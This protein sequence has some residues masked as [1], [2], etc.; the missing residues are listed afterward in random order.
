MT[1][2]QSGKA[3]KPTGKSSVR[4]VTVLLPNEIY[5]TYE[6]VARREYITIPQVVTRVA[7]EFAAT[8]EQASRRRLETILDY[9]AKRLGRQEGPAEPRLAA[10]PT[11]RNRVRERPGADLHAELFSEIIGIDRDQAKEFF[12]Q[13]KQGSSLI[14][15]NGL[16]LLEV[17]APEAL[18]FECVVECDVVAQFSTDESESADWQVTLVCRQ[19][20]ASLL[21]TGPKFHGLPVMLEFSDDSICDLPPEADCVLTVDGPSTIAFASFDVSSGGTKSTVSFDSIAKALLELSQQ[22]ALVPLPGLNT[23]GLRINLGRKPS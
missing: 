14:G 21:F 12:L 22:N 6:R 17:S 16:A 1:T 20:K 18:V 15:K 2:R 3:K 19:G 7:I 9:K 10:D 8:E 13:S 23:K 11:G 4:R 5:E